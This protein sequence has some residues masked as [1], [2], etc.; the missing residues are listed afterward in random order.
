MLLV[1]DSL[2]IF[3]GLPKVPV[4]TLDVSSRQLKFAHRPWPLSELPQKRA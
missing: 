3:D 1:V 4:E 2:L